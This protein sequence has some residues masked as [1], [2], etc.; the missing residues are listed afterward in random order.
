MA[1][2]DRFKNGGSPG[3]DKPEREESRTKVEHRPRRRERQGKR[4]ASVGATTTD[5]SH[6]LKARIHRRMVERHQPHQPGH[7]RSADASGA[8]RSHHIDAGDRRRASRSARP[9]GSLSSTR[10]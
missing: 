7:D 8:D 5:R 1:L 4:R 6:G 3:R 10:S 9:S 2:R